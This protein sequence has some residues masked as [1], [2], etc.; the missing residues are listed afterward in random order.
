MKKSFC[1]FCANYLP[2]IGGVERYVY[3]LAQQLVNRG[4]EVTVVT[5][6]VFGLLPHE[7]DENG[8]EIFRM[9]CYNFMKGRYP[10]LKRDSDFEKLDKL[11]CQKHFWM[12]VR[13]CAKVLLAQHRLVPMFPKSWRQVLHP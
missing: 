10:I 11:L 3:N 4:H 2:I 1:L 8:I 7:I 6:N 13:I 5:S 12:Q 9:P